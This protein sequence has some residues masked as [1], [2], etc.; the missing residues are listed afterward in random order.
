MNKF[1]QK[2][3]TGK[4]YTEIIKNN[5]FSAGDKIMVA[6]SGGADSICL[7]SVLT[8]LKDKLNIELSVAHFNHRLRGEESDEDEKF[9]HDFCQRQG[10]E[11]YIGR[12]EKENKYKSEDQARIAR[13][14]FFEKLLAGE[15]VDKIALAH[16]LNDQAETVL[17]RLIRGSGFRGLKAIPRER[18]NFIRPLLPISRSEI[19]KYLECHRQLF[20]TDYSNSDVAFVRNKIRHEILPKIAEINPNIVE[21]LGNSTKNITD[22]YDY[23]E[24]SARQSLGSIITDQASHSLSLDYKRWLILHPALKRQTLRLVIADI[25]DLIDITSKQIEE[26][27]EVLERG[28]GKKM[29]ALPHSLRIGLDGG[30]IKI[31]KIKKES[32]DETK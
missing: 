31:E 12:A 15:S 19:E 26:V 11:C 4:V 1:P 25:T 23:I 14:D 16:N 21:T 18:Q 28:R 5:L 6:V 20:R 27:L 22:D 32:K 8:E 13:Y 29:K 3:I 10:I 24:E 30:K 17:L 7:L 9:V 2:S